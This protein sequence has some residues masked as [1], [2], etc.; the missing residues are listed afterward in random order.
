MFYFVN[1]GASLAEKIP[2]TNVNPITY[3]KKN[4]TRC[5]QLTP[6]CEEEIITIL[7][8]LKNSSPGWDG[9][10]PHIVKLTYSIFMK[11]LLHICNLSILHGVFPNELKIAKVIPL[12]KGGDS[13]LLVN[14]RPVSILPVLSKLFERLMYDR[15][16]KFIEEME[17][18]YNLQFGFR[19]LHSTALA[20]MFLAQK[21][22]G[23]T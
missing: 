1:I 22:S 4:V 5:I 13:M 18:L 10:S 14:Y 2:H 23:Q 15:L 11:P 12:Y 3:V 6:V 19:K 8:N 16:F 7:K 17:L 9:I 20:L 21:N